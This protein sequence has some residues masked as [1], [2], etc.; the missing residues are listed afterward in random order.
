VSAEGNKRKIRLQ[1]L[2]GLELGADSAAP[3]LGGDPASANLEDDIESYGG[4]RIGGRVCD[5][6]EEDEEK[7]PPLVHKNR[8]SKTSNDVPIQ[9]LSGLVNLQ[10]LTIS[11]IDHALEENIPE[12]LL[13]ELPETGSAGIHAVGGPSSSK[14]PQKHD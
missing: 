2:S 9:A 4:T 11:A 3:V 13:L 1:R 14:C 7:I 5:E 12:D 8:R 6:D 10:R